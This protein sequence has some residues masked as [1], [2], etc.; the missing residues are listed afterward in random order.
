MNN[1]DDNNDLIFAE[2][3]YLL[4]LYLSGGDTHNEY[5]ANPTL[6]SSS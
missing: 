6:R 2:A 4:V 3:L 1:S 5:L